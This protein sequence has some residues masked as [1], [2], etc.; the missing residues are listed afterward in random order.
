MDGGG[1]HVSSSGISHPAVEPTQ[2][3]RRPP[4]WIVPQHGAH[5][6]P[7][8]RAVSTARLA[9]PLVWHAAAAPAAALPSRET[10]TDATVTG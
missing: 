9:R 8:A 1:H 2:P 6:E 10:A 4:L 7:S 3:P 5:F